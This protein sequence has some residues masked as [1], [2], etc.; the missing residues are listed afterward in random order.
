MIY[1]SYPIQKIK[2]LSQDEIED[3]YKNI[4]NYPTVI[5]VED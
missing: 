2:Q 5:T 3:E 1:N 4:F